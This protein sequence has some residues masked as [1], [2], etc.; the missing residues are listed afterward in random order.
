MSKLSMPDT[1][2]PAS[3]SAGVIMSQDAC[4]KYWWPGSNAADVALASPGDFY[5]LHS[6]L[7]ALHSG[8]RSM[9][10]AMMLEKVQMASSLLLKPC[11]AHD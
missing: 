5:L 4:A 9:H 2:A 11:A 3:P 8:H 10:V 1:E 7:G 6:M